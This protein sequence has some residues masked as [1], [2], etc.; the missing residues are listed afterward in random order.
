MILSE[1]K[2]VN[3]NLYG[4]FQVANKF[5]SVFINNYIDNDLLKFTF[6]TAKFKGRIISF[7]Q[8]EVY[9]DFTVM[10]TE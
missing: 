5:N 2:L 10:L 3:G 7:H 1:I 4:Y 8:D 9:T 6:H